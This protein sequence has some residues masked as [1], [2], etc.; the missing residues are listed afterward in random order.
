MQWNFT[1]STLYIFLHCATPFSAA[2]VRHTG[3]MNHCMIQRTSVPRSDW[4]AAESSNFQE[5]LSLTHCLKK[6]Y[7]SKMASFFKKVGRQISNVVDKMEAEASKRIL[8]NKLDSAVYTNCASIDFFL[9]WQVPSQLFWA[10]LVITRIT[11]TIF[12]HYDCMIT[13]KLQLKL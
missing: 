11:V 13:C 5:T 12:M 4:Y 6:V 9:M 2:R 3:S 10:S 7:E 1:C 8:A